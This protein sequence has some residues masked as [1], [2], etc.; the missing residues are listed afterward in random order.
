MSKLI[1]NNVV[2]K[3]VMRKIQKRTLAELSDI[4]VNSFGPNGS[5]SCIKKENILTR[6][7]KD[8]HTIIS[9]IQYNGVIE[10]SIKDDIESITRHIVKTVGDGTTSA[11]ILS[12]KIFDAIVDTPELNKYQPSTIVK[13]LE[14][15][16]ND[17][18]DRIM[19]SKKELTIEDVYDIAMISTNGNEY[20]SSILSDIYK[21]FGTS[22]FIDVSPSIGEEFV[23]KEYDGMTI[24]CGYADIC[25]V[26]NTED[27]TAVVDH[28]DVYFFEHPID[29]KE[30]GVYLD[31]IISNN[32][33]TPVNSKKY[34]DIVPTV[35]FAPKISIDCTSTMESLVSIMAQMP[36]GN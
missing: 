27:N 23:L 7:T 29:T 17:I 3:D 28:P 4:L 26:T 2:T 36:A 33:I 6:Y 15:V 31:C 13:E 5:N 19:A 12:S 30:L 11:V 22:V 9:A 8:G 25:Y 18:K 14:E 20:V 32:I 16:A 1:I 21:K 24:N 35:I 10:Q 34:E